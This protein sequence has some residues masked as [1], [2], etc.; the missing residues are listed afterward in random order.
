MQV[1]K[2]GIQVT[3]IVAPAA[4]VGEDTHGGGV[5]HE[6]HYFEVHMLRGRRGAQLAR[7]RAG[8]ESR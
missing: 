3:K 4:M 6:S 5:T 2:E 7:G 8:G 1:I